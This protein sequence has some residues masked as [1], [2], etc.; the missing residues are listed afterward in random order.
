MFSTMCDEIWRLTERLA[1]FST[2]MGFFPGVNV[3]MLLHV[4][5]LVKPLATIFAWKRARVWVNQHMGGE[6]RWP[7]K[8]FVA[9]FTR[10][11]FFVGMYADVLLQ[12]HAMPE[13]FPAHLTLVGTPTWVRA[14]DVDFETV[15]GVEAFITFYAL[16]VCVLRY[17]NLG[18]KLSGFSDFWHATISRLF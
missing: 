3:R 16:V 10:K 14:P 12:A 4:A 17:F 2:N 1:A 13:C 11:Q 6:S 15:R 5:F 18:G 8:R 7:F 9:L